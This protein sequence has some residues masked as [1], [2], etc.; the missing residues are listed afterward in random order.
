MFKFLRA[1]YI[2]D[3][4][5][6]VYQL[7]DQNVYNAFPHF[8][9]SPITAL[10]CLCIVCS[11]GVLSLFDAFYTKANYETCRYSRILF[12]TKRVIT[13]GNA[14]NKS[15]D[16]FKAKQLHFSVKSGTSRVRD[17]EVLDVYLDYA[18]GFRSKRAIKIFYVLLERVS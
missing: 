2:P 6:N 18:Y 12:S 14:N 7:S 13:I 16:I 5:Y 9:L 11:N 8:L 15:N 3:A 4:V 1:S 17:V 10:L